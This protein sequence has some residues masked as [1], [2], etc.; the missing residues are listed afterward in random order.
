MLTVKQIEA[1]N[2]GDCHER[3][4][5]GNGLYLRVF[6]S[7]HKAFQARVNVQ[8]KTKWITLGSFPNMT[9]KEARVKSAVAKGEISEDMS[10]TIDP[11]TFPIAEPKTAT[12]DVTRTFFDLATEWFEIKREGL[13][14]GKHIHQ[15]WRTLETYVIPHLGH[16]PITDIRRKDIIA[17]FRPIWRTKNETASRTLNRVKE[18]LEL[19][20]ALEIIE[21]NPA[22]FSTKVAFGRVVKQVMGAQTEMR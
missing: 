9:L 20:C 12:V 6:K 18:V 14:N 17:V 22:V 8:G 13:S 11:P 10:R 3:V 21:H 4:P 15:N 19:A 2:F 7:G 5:D 16:V 1:L